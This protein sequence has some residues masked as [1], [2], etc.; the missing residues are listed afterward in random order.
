M[1]ESSFNGVRFT[2][3]A[4]GYGQYIINAT[5]HGRHIS[6]RCTDSEAYDYVD[7]TENKSKY[8]AARRT[9]YNLIKNQI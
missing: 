5:Y 2:I 4:I 8:M 3:Q 6:V 7:D 1:E 9:A